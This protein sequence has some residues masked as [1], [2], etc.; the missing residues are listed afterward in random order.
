MRVH[1]LAAELGMKSSVLLEELKELG[2]DYTAAASG[3]SDDDAEKIRKA[4]AALGASGQP[5]DGAADTEAPGA[6]D[7]AEASAAPVKAEAAMEASARGAGGWRLTGK[8]SVT[9][10]S[11]KV[12]KGATITERQYRTLPARVKKFFE[13]V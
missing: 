3:V 7:A 1:E 8:G 10:G 9:A 2:F 11:V 4:Y 12:S 5:A 13:H 6:E